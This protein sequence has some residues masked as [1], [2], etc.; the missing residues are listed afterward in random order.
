MTAHT[1]IARLGRADREAVGSTLVSA[2][3]TEIDF[4]DV[5]NRL[6]F[7]LGNALDQLDDV[8]LVPSERA[9]DL[10]LL[11]A[12]VLAADTRVSREGTAQDGWTRELEVCIPVAEPALWQSVAPLLQTTL[13]F[14]TGDK[15]SL[16]FRTRPES[17]DRLAPVTENLRT[18]HPDHVCLF[19][20]G[21]DSFIGAID[22]F[23]NGATP[24]LVSH[25]WDGIASQHQR[26]CADRLKARFPDARFHHLRA[27]VGFSTD[28]VNDESLVEDTLRGRSF[29]F[30]ALAVL[31]ADAVGGGVPIHVPENGWISL[32]VPLDPVRLGSLST[33]T[34]HPFYMARMNE[35]L[36]AIGVRSRLINPYRLK[37]KGQMARECADH[38]FLAA[39]AAETMSCSSPGKV[40]FAGETPK[41]CG[42]CVPCLIRRASLLASGIDDET[43]YYLDDLHA[44]V[45]SSD[46][47]EGRDIRSFQLAISRL[48]GKPDRARFDIHRPG[49]LDDAPA[50]LEAYAA[51]YVAG[52]EEV[53]ALLEGVRTEPP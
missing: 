2:Q 7:G 27:R 13:D 52:L 49:P 51:T 25:Y 37:T 8:G 35:L 30:F 42:Y 24:L 43:P 3:I 21:L 31:S 47:S 28:T 39:Y 45:I 34:T 14:L 1:L 46:K 23:A 32:N 22:L 19:S 44:R 40:R 18:A 10:T 33:R 15:W 16:R 36:Q 53:G 41:H 11:A 38:D 9:I 4:I 17:H 5:Y 48:L 50:D 20:G 6:A 29:M 12:T 26:M